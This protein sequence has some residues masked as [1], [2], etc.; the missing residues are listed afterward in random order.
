VSNIDR[1][2]PASLGAMPAVLDGEIC[3]SVRVGDPDAVPADVRLCDG[4][5]IGKWPVLLDFR[6]CRRMPRR[7]DGLYPAQPGSGA[8]TSNLRIASS[9]L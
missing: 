5:K 8:G 4:R 7:G 1:Y 9:D 2:L 3:G 6:E